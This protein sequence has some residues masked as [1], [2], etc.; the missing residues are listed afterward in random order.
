MTY[1]LTLSFRVATCR[2]LELVFPLQQ[3]DTSRPYIYGEQSG[4]NITG[5]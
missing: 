1:F 2:V 5:Q 4:D 3:R